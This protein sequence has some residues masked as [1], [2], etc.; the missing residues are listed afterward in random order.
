MPT[1]SD[2]RSLGPN[3]HPPPDP[4]GNIVNAAD[5]STD[6]PSTEAAPDRD[7]CPASALGSKQ[8]LPIGVAPSPRRSFQTHLNL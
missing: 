7:R 5:N 8:A 4:P 3:W 1:I 2:H 6:T